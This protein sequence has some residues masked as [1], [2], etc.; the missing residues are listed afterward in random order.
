[1]MPHHWRPL[2]HERN[3]IFK[4]KQHTCTLHDPWCH[5][6][7]SQT[8]INSKFHGA[9]KVQ[10]FSGSVLNAFACG[11]FSYPLVQWIVQRFLSWTGS[12]I[13]RL[14]HCF[15]FNEC[16]FKF[17]EAMHGLLVWF[18]IN[19]NNYRFQNPQ[20][21]LW[22]CFVG[23]PSLQHWYLRIIRLCWAGRLATQSMTL[24]RLEMHVLRH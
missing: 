22:I 24:N 14:N 20:N 1:M 13:W 2:A 6:L 5:Y 11:L 15:F 3:S 18:T 16:N 23:G 17:L 4:C 10:F 8:T 9:I 7:E 12:P 21:W 19:K